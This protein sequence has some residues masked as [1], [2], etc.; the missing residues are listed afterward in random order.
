MRRRSTACALHWGEYS[1]RGVTNAWVWD[2][3]VVQNLEHLSFSRRALAKTATKP[4]EFVSCSALPMR[5]RVLPAPAKAESVIDAFFK[6]HSAILSTVILPRSSA[7]VE[8]TA[9]W[10]SPAISRSFCFGNF[11]AIRLQGL[12]CLLAVGEDA[13]VV[14]ARLMFLKVLHIRSVPRFYGNDR[15]HSMTGGN[16]RECA[17][18]KPA[19]N[20]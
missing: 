3:E 17:R 7:R 1:A 12:P 9:A 11:Q 19:Q 4:Q 6:D 8:W 13:S 14:S 18:R 2:S 10:G 20:A 15:L 5:R 16:D